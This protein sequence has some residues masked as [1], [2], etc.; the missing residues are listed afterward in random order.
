L[1]ISLIVFPFCPPNSSITSSRLFRGRLLS[2]FPIGLAPNI[3]LGFLSF[4][5]ITCPYHC[6][7]FF[8]SFAKLLENNS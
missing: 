4:A 3:C 6:R 7:F 8:I 1:S 2:L 5:F